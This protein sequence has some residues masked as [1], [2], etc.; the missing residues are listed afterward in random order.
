MLGK[1]FFLS[2]S[3]S[4]NTLQISLFSLKENEVSPACIKTCD[5]KTVDAL[6]WGRV[7]KLGNLVLPNYPASTEAEGLLAPPDPEAPIFPAVYY[8][9]SADFVGLVGDLTDAMPGNERKEWWI[10]E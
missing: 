6:H 4:R 1:N 10:N 2:F 7:L 5:G 8:A 3:S 9:G